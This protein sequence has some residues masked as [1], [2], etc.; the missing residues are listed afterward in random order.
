ML[1]LHLRDLRL[2]W[3][4]GDRCMRCEVLSLIHPALTFASI[5]LFIG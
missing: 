4:G 1:I 5:H 3:G 2:G